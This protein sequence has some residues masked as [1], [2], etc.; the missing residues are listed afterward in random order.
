MRKTL[1]FFFLI[2]LHTSIFGAIELRF[3]L[4]SNVNNGVT[5]TMT[6]DLEAKSDAGDVSVTN[7]ELRT[8]EDGGLKSAYISNS[9][10]FSNQL[11][12][13]ANYVIRKEEYV[14]GNGPNVDFI[15]VDYRFIT[16]RTKSIISGTAWT[17]IYTVE[18][19]YTV[20]DG[21][22]TLFSFST[23]NNWID[24]IQPQ[25]GT[26]DNADLSNQGLSVELTSFKISIVDENVELSWDTATEVNNY[27]F[28]IERQYQVS[29]SKN[30]GWQNIGFV[31]GY[32]N[33]NSPKSYTF[34]DESVESAGK[35]SYRLK[36]IDIDGQFEYSDL[37]EVNIALPSKLELLQ[38]YPNPFNPTT[39]ISYAIPND[40]FVTLTIYDILGN[41][42]IQ[43]ENSN[44]AAGTYSK[45]FDAAE[46]T[47]GIY[48][49]TLRSGK[50]VETKKML[51][52]K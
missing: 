49:Y 44:K 12:T 16:G 39:S 37:V 32:G 47:S 5:G 38:N 48:F 46:L 35:Y 24:G 40:G 27:G 28:E 1:I 2:A 4:I 15:R 17:R 10:V 43:L 23:G 50:Y 41:E 11:F 22:S 36:Q 34:T 26:L 20:T 21:S 42:V 45:T 3:R 30:Q 31:E 7:I 18:I 51:L 29:S 33:S 52:M 14:E 8:N 9:A 19:G 6:L 13:S 25:Y